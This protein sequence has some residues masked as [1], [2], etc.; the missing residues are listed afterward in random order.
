M[1]RKVCNL[2][3]SVSFDQKLLKAA[4]AEDQIAYT[5]IVTYFEPIIRMISSSYYL[6]GG[7]REDLIQEGRIALINAVRSFDTA[8]GDSFEKYA[9]ICI[10]RAMLSA[11][12]RD[13]RL[14]NTLLNTSVS[15][16]EELQLSDKSAED[17]V[18]GRERLLEVYEKI[19]DKLTDMERQVLSFFVDGYSYKEIADALGKN[20]KAVDNA[21]SRIRGKLQ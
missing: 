18:L 9:K 7:D 6:S 19:E 16:S 12:K 21:L 11:I 20:A 13:T 14:K 10:H 5:Q 8:K 17:I 1:D 15:L 3:K 2:E 4:K